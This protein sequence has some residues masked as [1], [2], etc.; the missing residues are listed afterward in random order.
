MSRRE[1][2]AVFDANPADAEEKCVELYQKLVLYFQ[3]NRR[4]DPE[5]LAQET[6]RR[7]FTRLQ[8]GQ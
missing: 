2:L 3:W 4:P 7:G 5:D 6:F 8:E 1:L